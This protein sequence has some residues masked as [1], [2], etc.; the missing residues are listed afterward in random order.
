M[1][2]ILQ[3]RRF[4]RRLREQIDRHGLEKTAG[5][6]SS[7]PRRSKTENVQ[8]AANRAPSTPPATSVEIR[9]H[10]L[11]EKEIQN[12]YPPT[13]SSEA[14]DLAPGGED[15]EIGADLSGSTTRDSASSS[16]SS[17][18]KSTRPDLL[19]TATTQDTT[20]TRLGQALTGIDVRSRTTNEGGHDRGKVFVVG[21]AGESDPLNPHNWSFT[22]RMST[23][24]LV[25]SIGL[26]VGFASSV[27]SAALQQARKDF[28]V[29]EVTESLA[30]GIY[31]VGFGFGAFFAAPVSETVG[32]NI[33]YIVTMSMFMIFV[34]ASAL[35]PTI[36]AQLAFRLLAGFWGSTPLTCAGGSIS[37]MWT[38]SERTAVFPIFATSAFW[39]PVLGPVVGGFI[40]ESKVVSWRWCEWVT[41]IWSGLILSLMLLFMPETYAPTLMKWKATHLRKIT[42]DQRYLSALEVQDTKFLDRLIHNMYRPF[43]LFAYEPIVVLFTLYLTV[44]YIVLFTFLTGFE[45][46][47]T[48]TFGLSQGVTFLCFAG[49]GVGFSCATLLVPWL[50]KRYKRALAAVQEQGGS[51]L[52]P[53]QRLIFAMIG[54]PF[55]PIGLFWMGWTAYPSIS[56]WSAIAATLPVGFSILAIFISTYQYLIDGFEA[57]A[58]SALV[59]ATF[60]RYVVAG[61]MIEV[62]IPMYKNLGVQWTLTVL[63]GI[64]AVM[65]PVPFIFFRYGAVIRKKSRYASNMS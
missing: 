41:L 49:I 50:Y 35:A 10:A 16:S 14:L 48:E 63:G 7:H 44:V 11:A 30:T 1:Q 4:E 2:S 6:I 25:A 61:A 33:V 26:I 9:D 17:S 39:G 27:D 38:P 40:G 15:K 37:D 54:A 43:V 13:Q 64:S 59:G 8:G 57:H 65:A 60:V 29:S 24:I 23:T 22:K 5:A 20:G 31:L 45:F 52:P 3:Y 55:L 62:S 51:R 28:G 19:S 47:F 18:S 36:G 42:G 58:A 46:I 34:M 53:E 21:F 32:R 56:V 12:E